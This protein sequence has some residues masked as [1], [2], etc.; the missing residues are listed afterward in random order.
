MKH[1][2]IV[3]HVRSNFL[4]G[5]GVASCCAALQ[6]PQWGETLAHQRE[7]KGGK[8]CDELWILRYAACSGVSKPFFF[9]F[10]NTCR[11]IHIAELAAPFFIFCFIIVMF[12]WGWP[13]KSFPNDWVS[14]SA[15]AGI[16][17]VHVNMI[18][19]VEDTCIGLCDACMSTE[20][21][22]RDTS[23]LAPSTKRYGLNIF[24]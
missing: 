11:Q 10:L 21:M 5:R 3:F 22:H 20:R 1:L 15:P 19:S 12:S 2:C 13:S 23:I 9:F 7:R 6:H 4:I 16:C 18:T 24:A 8:K 14:Y 17:T